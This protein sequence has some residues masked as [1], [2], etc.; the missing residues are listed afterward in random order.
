[1]NRFIL[2]IITTLNSAV[3]FSQSAEFSF[4]KKVK[5]Y[6]V[7]T[8]G[9]TLK[10]YFVYKNTGTEPLKITN[11]TVE[12]HCTEVKYPEKATLPNESDT[13]YFTFDS[14]GKYYAQDRT[15]LVYGNTKKE[16]NL[17]RFKVYVNP[18]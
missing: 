11:Y 14:A 1:M 17:I 9:D 8:E 13:L 4:D 10:G 12:C 6:G 2:I 15:I 18:K 7:I 3:L 16:L 5:K